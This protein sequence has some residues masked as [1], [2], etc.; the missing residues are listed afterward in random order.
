MAPRNYL[1]S[2]IVTGKA[3]NPGVN[4]LVQLKRLGLSTA[5]KLAIGDGSLAFCIAL[6]EE[7]GP[8]AEQRCSRT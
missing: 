4:C 1:L 6:Q 5:P 7:Y 3:P 2:S 8:V